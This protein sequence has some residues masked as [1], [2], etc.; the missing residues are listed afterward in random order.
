[1]MMKMIANK[2]QALAGEDLE[3]VT[4]K[5]D[6]A[7]YILTGTYK[8]K[9]GRTADVKPTQVDRSLVAV[10]A[11]KHNLE[12]LHAVTLHIDYRAQTAQATLYGIFKGDK[13][14]QPQPPTAL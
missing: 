7:T 5:V 3:H 14:Q 8:T 13:V 4:L 9:E 2:I 1:M 6:T 12:Q 10:L 11:L